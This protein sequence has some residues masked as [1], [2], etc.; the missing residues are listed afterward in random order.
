MLVIFTT[1]VFSQIPDGYYNSAQDLQ[2][3]ELKAT[4]NDII[5]GHTE[6]PYTSSSTDTW[7]ILK[8]ADRDTNNSENVVGIYSGFSMNGEAEYA[9]GKG[10]NRE[11]VWA[12]SRGDFG[13]DNGPGTDCHHLAAAD[14]STNSARNNRNFGWGDS[15]YTDVDANGV[16]NGATESKTHTTE[17]IWEPRDS[18]KGDVA[19]MIFYMATRYEGENSEPDLELTDELLTNTDK[20]PLQAQQSVLLKWNILDP[21]SEEEQARNEVIYSFQ[22]NRNPFIDH[23][24][25][26]NK[27][28]GTTGISSS[29]SVSAKLYPNPTNNEVSIL[30]DEDFENITIYNVIGKVVRKFSGVQK[31]FFVGDLQKGQYILVL[32]NSTRNLALP[33]MIID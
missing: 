16:Y 23:P 2:G 3:E 4:L 28:W 20:S 8:V 25:Y 18:K 22:G 14:I 30:S 32:N 33:L 21:V 13:T 17:W 26:V 12:K 1:N 9:S 31:T 15:F 27:I 11:H 6:Y 29:K 7:D 24:E 5:S 10:W 19:R